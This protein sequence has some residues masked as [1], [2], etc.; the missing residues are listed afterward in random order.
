[1]TTLLVPC[2]GLGTRLGQQGIAKALTPIGGSTLLGT[3]LDK[4]AD[5]FDEIVIVSSLAH[6]KVFLDFLQ[7]RTGLPRF[8]VEIQESPLGSLNA[9]N[10]G[11]KGLKEDCIVVWGDQIGVSR[12]TIQLL[13]EHR[14]LGFHLAVPRIFT[15]NPYVWLNFSANSENV[16]SIGRRR[17]GDSIDKGWADLGVFYLSNKALE[18]LRSI[19][20][21]LVETQ[22]A[23]EIDL[24]YAIP[25]LSRESKSYFPIRTDVSE[26]IAVNSLEDLKVAEEYVNE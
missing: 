24:T 10:A 17:D 3:I 18:H 4:V 26:L 16:L 23:R 22:S 11:S 19:E 25:I 2:G 20:D 14:N 1:M 6:E 8:R 15:Q 9:V 7:S 21:E 13:I 12:S 5:L